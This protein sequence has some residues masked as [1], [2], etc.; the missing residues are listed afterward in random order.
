MIVWL[1]PQRN[2]CSPVISAARVGEQVGLTKKRSSEVDSPRNFSSA[3]VF[4][5]GLPCAE[6]SP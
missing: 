6:R 5:F 1:I 2:S 4:T 3:G